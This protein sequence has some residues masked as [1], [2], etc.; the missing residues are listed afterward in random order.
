MRLIS[1]WVGCLNMKR[2]YLGYSLQSSAKVSKAFDYNGDFVQ[3]FAKYYV[4]DGAF[5]VY[6][7]SFYPEEFS[8]H[9]KLANFFPFPVN[10]ELL[11]EI[12]LATVECVFWVR[13]ED[14]LSRMKNKNLI[15]V[16]DFY[17]EKFTWDD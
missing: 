6:S 12:D 1:R 4:E 15:F 17:I 9:E 2:I 10:M 13:Y 7:K 3:I 14:N 11:K 16:G 5:E 8:S